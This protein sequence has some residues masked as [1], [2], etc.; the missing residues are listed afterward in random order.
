MKEV[1][2]FV[3]GRVQGVGYRAWCVK[4]AK[5]LFL[6]GWVRNRANGS[7]EVKAFG[8]IEAIDSFVLFCQKGPLWANV[9]HIEPVHIPTAVQP[10]IVEGIFLQKP[11]L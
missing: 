9:T 3:Y 6:S 1:H 10:E 11:T 5:S 8:S 4:Q 7:V 2:F